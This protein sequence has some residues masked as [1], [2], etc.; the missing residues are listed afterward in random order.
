MSRRRTKLFQQRR[1]ARRLCLPTGRRIQNTVSSRFI[2]RCVEKAGFVV[3]A[4][5]TPIHTSMLELLDIARSIE[6]SNV[7]RRASPER[8]GSVI[9][10]GTDGATAAKTRERYNYTDCKTRAQTIAQDWADLDITRK[11]IITT[12]RL[13]REKY[14]KQSGGSM[15]AAIARANKPPRWEEGIEIDEDDVD[16]QKARE[17]HEE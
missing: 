7:V 10:L 11:A 6:F 3:A 2:R 16:Q 13:L 14:P 5:A 15:D 9:T 4:S 17:K 1:R 8:D 12:V